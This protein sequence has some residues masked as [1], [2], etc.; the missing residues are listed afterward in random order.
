MEEEVAPDE[1]AAPVG[2]PLEATE[3]NAG[4]AGRARCEHRVA[5][6]GVEQQPQAPPRILLRQVDEDAIALLGLE[7]W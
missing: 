3:A 5:R 7:E 6:P 2:I 4:V 1:R